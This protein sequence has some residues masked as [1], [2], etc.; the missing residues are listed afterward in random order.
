M[1][2]KKEEIEYK[3]NEIQNV[4]EWNEQITILEMSCMVS[5]MQQ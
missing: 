4:K 5:L 3:R 1:K 2:M